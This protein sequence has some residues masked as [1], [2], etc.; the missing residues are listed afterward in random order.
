MPLFA[1]LILGSKPPMILH[2]LDIE[3]AWYCHTLNLKHYPPSLED[4]V[5]RLEKIAKDGASHNRFFFKWVLGIGFNLRK[6]RQ[7]AVGFLWLLSVG[8]G[9]AAEAKR[10]K[11]FLLI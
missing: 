6:W 5:C 7:I 11:V 9:F 3:W 1:D 8:T 2:P 10:I 4:E